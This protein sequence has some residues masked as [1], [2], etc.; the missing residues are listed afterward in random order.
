VLASRTAKWSAGAALACVVVLAATW[1]LLI[2]PRRAQVAETRDQQVAAQQANDV[3]R[4]KVAQ[5][6]AQF[7]ELPQT[8]AELARLHQQLTPT[9]DMPALVRTISDL[10]TAAG[11]SLTNITP[12]VASAL[13]AASGTAGSAPAAGGSGASAADAKGVVSIPMS[14]VVNGDYYQ[15][16]GF[17]RLLQTQMSRALVISGLQLD[18]AGSGLGLVTLNL[19]GSVFALPDTTSSAS[20]GSAVSSGSAGSAGSAASP[21]AA[22][23]AVSQSS[24]GSQ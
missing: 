9:A 3:L 13:G 14:I 16:V 12:G 5:L 8:K 23:S 2:S 20:S 24:S 7:A 22:A 15:V 17:V 11:T 1:F 10:S 19:T 6:K 21:V 18:Q 4:A